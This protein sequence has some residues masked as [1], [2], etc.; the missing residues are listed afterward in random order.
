MAVTEYSSD[1]T[2]VEVLPG[3]Y[4]RIHRKYG[5]DLDQSHVTVINLSIF[6]RQIPSGLW[7]RP[8]VP[9][10]GPMP[11]FLRLLLAKRDCNTSIAPTNEQSKYQTILHLTRSNERMPNPPFHSLPRRA[12]DCSPIC[13]AQSRSRNMQYAPA[14]VTTVDPSRGRRGLYN[15][16]LWYVWSAHHSVFSQKC[17]N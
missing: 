17:L 7:R 16:P 6:P 10:V 9:M 1:N 8:R 15:K 3:Y 13:G 2:D 12:S 11:D 14:F 5:L 4:I